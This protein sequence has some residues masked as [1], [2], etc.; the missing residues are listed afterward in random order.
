MRSAV[1]AAVGAVAFLLLPASAYATVTVSFTSPT[2]T[3]TMGAGSDSTTI[4]DATAAGDIAI[5]NVPALPAGCTPDPS[6]NTVDCPATAVHVNAAGTNPANLSVTL[7]GLTR[8]SATVS[9]GNGSP[10]TLTAAGALTKAF[11]YTSGV[12]SPGVNTVDLS[13]VTGGLPGG[14]NIATLGSGNDVKLPTTQGNLSVVMGAG[15]SNTLDFGSDTAD[16]SPVT[17]TYTGAR[18]LRTS[19]TASFSGVDTLIGTGGTLDDTFVA[20]T[21][22]NGDT[23][24]GGGGT[25]RLDLTGAAGAVDVNLQAHTVTGAQSLTIANFQNVTA[26]NANGNTIVAGT[27]GTDET[28]NGGSGTGNTIS[29]AGITDPFKIDLFHSKATDLSRTR[30][31]T[32]TGFQNAVGSPTTTTQ[33]SRGLATRR[34]TAGAA[35]TTRSALRRSRRRSPST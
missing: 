16:A 27:G 6:P 33:S 25:N 4:A 14:A 30:V 10:E 26:P 7:L 20:G 32:I 17:F 11:S 19:A 12:G 18:A 31:D 13:G 21:A 15:P 3:V 9:L 35:P 22:G 1:G 5:S 24:E 8:A 23:L 29:Y 34:S 28:L 2:A